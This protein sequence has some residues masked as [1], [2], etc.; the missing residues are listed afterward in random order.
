MPAKRGRPA[1]PTALKKLHN[2][3]RRPLNDAE[4]E[5]PA[6]DAA[7]QGKSENVVS[8]ADARPKIT[9]TS[10]G[11][12]VAVQAPEHVT[13]I[14]LDK[15][16]ELAPSLANAKVLTQWD[17]DA[18]ARYCNLVKTEIQ[19][20]KELDDLQSGS[21]LKGLLG[22]TPNGM[23][24]MNALLIVRNAASR[25]ASKFGALLG[26]DPSSRS[27]LKVEKEDESD[28]WKEFA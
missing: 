26:L 3:G 9:K 23:L 20:Q 24:Q 17:F 15:W 10:R 27:S 14:A 2:A 21:V 13:G 8:L 28:G 16:N 25:D 6:L 1:K 22:K 7:P 12:V 19:A 11:E 4:P 18:L 5:G